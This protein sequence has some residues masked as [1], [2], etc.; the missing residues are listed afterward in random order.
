M[1]TMLAD[2]ILEKVAQVNEIYYRLV[3]VVSPPGADSS[4]AFDKIAA[5]TG[6]SLVNVN[7][8][9]SEQMLTM[10]TRQR[11]LRAASMLDD[12]I[13]LNNGEAVLLE[14]IE[15]LFDPSLRLDPLRVLQGLSRRR[16]IVALWRGQVQGNYLTYAEPDHP[17]YR[18]Y[19]TNDLVLLHQAQPLR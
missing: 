8:A 12:I 7:L 19:A 14:S 5:Q 2:Q 15:I 1:V 16:T 6:F 11:S 3:I 17:E 18:R 10:T 4:G 9:L 13:A